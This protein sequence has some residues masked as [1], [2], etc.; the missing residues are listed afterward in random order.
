M[1][2]GVH[3]SQNAPTSIF[4]KETVTNNHLPSS[5]ELQGGEAVSVML[6]VTMY[7]FGWYFPHPRGN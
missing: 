3:P 5:I 1:P 7:A 6:D 4:G 2:A